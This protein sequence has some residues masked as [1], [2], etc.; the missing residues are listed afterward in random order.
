MKG[1]THLDDVIDHGPASFRLIIDHDTGLL[2]GRI[3]AGLDNAGKPS[4]HRKD[5]RRTASAV[6]LKR[7]AVMGAIESFRKRKTR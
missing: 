7:T 6:C 5:A 3:A 1:I 4:K 2:F